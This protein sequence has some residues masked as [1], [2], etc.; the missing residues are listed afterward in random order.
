M[1]QNH[2]SSS[3]LSATRAS[4]TETKFLVDQSVDC[5]LMLGPFYHLIDKAQRDKAVSEAYRVLKTDGLFFAAAIN[6]LGILHG[7][8]ENGSLF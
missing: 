4:A 2:L 1:D 5:V 3:V 6:R 7:L 8:F